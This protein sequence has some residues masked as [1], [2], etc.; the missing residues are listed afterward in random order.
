M[1]AIKCS[2]MFLCNLSWWYGSLIAGASFG[3]FFRWATYSMLQI[4]TTAVTALILL[5]NIHYHT[6]SLIHLGRGYHFKRW[7]FYRESSFVVLV[8]HKVSAIHP[9]HFGTQVATANILKLFA[10]L[11]YR[12]RTYHAFALYFTILPVA[13]KYKPMAAQ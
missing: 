6:I 8:F 5:H 12:L 4:Y 2:A 13:V 7:Y 9:A 10:R 3:S 1:L 11:Q